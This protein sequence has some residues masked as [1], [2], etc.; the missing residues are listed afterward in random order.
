MIQSQNSCTLAV[1]DSIENVT[2][3]VLT[4]LGGCLPTPPPRPQRC[5]NNLRRGYLG[6][7]PGYLGRVGCTSKA[8]FAAFGE[9][10]FV[11]KELNSGYGHTTTYATGAQ[12]QDSG[13]GERCL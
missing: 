7:S 8:T 4:P 3:E 11:I 12:F 6:L 1:P 5:T 2:D 9:R 10:H 13:L